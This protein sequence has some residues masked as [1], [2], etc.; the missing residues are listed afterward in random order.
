MEWRDTLKRL[1]GPVTFVVA[2]VVVLWIILPDAA[3]DGP[4][5]PRKRNLT[6]IAVS[7]REYYDEKGSLPTSDDGPEAALYLLKGKAPAEVFDLPEHL[8]E[9]KHARYDDGARRLVGGN[10]LYL[11]QPVRMDERASPVVAVL[12]E[13]TPDGGGV[14]VLFS[15]GHAEWINLPSDTRPADLLGK[16]DDQMPRHRP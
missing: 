14:Y 7:L 11:N 4:V 9:N 10:Y 1:I 13:A 6:V 12:V 8:R 15:D 3:V 16:R 5:A 2:A